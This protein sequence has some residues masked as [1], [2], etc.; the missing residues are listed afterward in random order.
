MKVALDAA[1]GLE[2]ELRFAA[3]A[4][5]DTTGTLEVFNKLRPRLTATQEKF[6][7]WALAQQ[8][9]AFTMGWRGVK[10]DLKDRDAAREVAEKELRETAEAIRRD[11]SVMERWDGT[12]LET[13]FCA[14]GEKTPS[15]NLQRHKWPR[16]KVGDPVIDHADMRCLR[17]GAARLRA[18]PYEP[19]SGAQ[20]IHLL[21]GRLGLPK[22][23][24]KTDGVTVD[25]DALESLSRQYPRYRELLDKL[26]HF[27]DL[28]KQ[29][30]FLGA[31]LSARGRFHSTFNPVAPWTARWSS[32][33]NPFGEGGNLQ[34]IAE[35]HRRV[36]TPDRGR[37][38]GYADLKTAESMLVAYIAGDEGY[39][40]AHTRDVHTF[41]CR[42]IWPEGLEAAVSGKGKKVATEL[43]PWT[44]DLKKDK[45]IAKGSLPAW[46]F[47]EGHDF[48]F[49]SKRTQHG[50]NYGLT[51]RG[52][53]I[54]NKISVKAAETA[55]QRF[56]AAF[57]GI[58][59]YHG[60]IKD[61]VRQRRSLYN[62]LGRSINLM[63]RP[64]DASTWRQGLCYGPQSGVG[65]ILNIGLWRLWRRDPELVELLAQVHDAILFQYR[66]EREAE[67]I[68]AISTEMRV[69]VPITD[70]RGD[71]RTC[72]IPVEL[73][74]GWNWS[75]ASPTN[76]Q[77]LEEVPC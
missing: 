74:V 15:G 73:A 38:L 9:P 14:R 25:D 22:Q 11:P 10:V 70:I 19:S 23:Y 37:K 72:V 17:C 4:A 2:G 18:V 12:E 32:S 16:T 66:P 52:M 40:E 33:K 20:T 5:L 67:V 43:R 3:Y 13:G 62:P 55:Q 45:E 68:D 77:G 44:G 34:N 29:V 30:Q 8:S 63:H 36:F 71:T 49:Q 57:P 1:Q 6:Y 56:F 76:P 48:R 39:I 65:D 21:Y 54:L 61:R 64:W 35:K 51:P 7:C 53:A 69:E 58:P 59:E 47:E 50:S 75:K 26:R 27:R 60:Y 46:D 31:K 41:V 24:G 42:A 28:A